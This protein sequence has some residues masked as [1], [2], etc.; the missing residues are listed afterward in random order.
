M[1]QSSSK[2]LHWA[3]ALEIIQLRYRPSG[4]N[5]LPPK[6][7]SFGGILSATS[8]G[9]AFFCSRFPPSTQIKPEATPSVW[10]GATSAISANQHSWRAPRILTVP[11]ID[12]PHAPVGSPQWRKTR[13][14]YCPARHWSCG[15]ALEITKK[16]NAPLFFQRSG[17]PGAVRRSRRFWI[18]TAVKAVP[19]SAV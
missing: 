6:T 19:Q 2:R 15:G 14:L 9:C 13:L 11:L 7:S 1:L 4:G 17:P 16:P 8:P 3:P 18:L 10:C 5:V 12:A